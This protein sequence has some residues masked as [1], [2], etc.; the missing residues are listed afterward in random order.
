MDITWLGYACFRLKGRDASVVTDPFPPSSGLSLGSLSADIVTLSCLDPNHSYADGVK[1]GRRVL[2]GP[3]EYEISSVDI[4]GVRTFLDSEKGKLR[5]YNTSYVVELDDVRVCHLGAIAHVP[6]ADQ[7]AAMGNV[8]VL[9]VPVGGGLMLKPNQAAEAVNAIEPKLV[10][11]M[12][13]Q[14]PGLK[15]EFEP[16]DRFLKEMGLKTVEPQPKLTVTR[17]SLP[18]DGAQAQIMVLTPSTV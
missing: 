3:G 18:L 15:V 4:V 1:V 6:A 13:Y 17:A 5:G 10:V 12:C 8:D 16:L 11:P 14:Q 2:K 7:V 9:L